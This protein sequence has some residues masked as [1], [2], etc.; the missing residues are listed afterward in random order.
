MNSLRDVQIPTKVD[1]S[2]C[3]TSKTG[4]LTVPVT[5]DFNSKPMNAPVVTLMSVAE[6]KI[7]PGFFTRLK[8]ALNNKSYL[9]CSRNM[10]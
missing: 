10:Q 5:K 1:V 4:Q 2:M 7:R 6:D 8:L 3:A 9:L